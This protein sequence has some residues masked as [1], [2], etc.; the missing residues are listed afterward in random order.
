MKTKITNNRTLKCFE[1]FKQRAVLYGFSFDGESELLNFNFFHTE[2]SNF[3]NISATFCM[4]KMLT[5]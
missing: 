5:Q 3:L 2:F 4:V 1:E